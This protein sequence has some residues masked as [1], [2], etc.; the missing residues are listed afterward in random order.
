[1]LKWWSVITSR[2][3]L[4]AII[5]SSGWRQRLVYQIE[6]VCVCVFAYS[7]RTD[8]SICTKIGTLI[9]WGQKEILEKPKFRKCAMSSSPGEGS[10]YSSETKHDRR[11]ALRQKLFDSKR[12]QKRRPELQK[13]ILCSSSSEDGLCSS[14][15]RHKKVT[16]PRTKLFVS[17]E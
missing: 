12:L 10:F 3:I 11:T 2:K 17:M 7:A 1:M 16:G 14:Q 9:S 8:T 5:N 4:Y 6:I 15:T 13:H